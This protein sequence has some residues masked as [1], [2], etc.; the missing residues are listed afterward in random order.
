MGYDKIMIIIFLFC[1]YCLSAQ[2]LK[3]PKEHYRYEIK[4]DS[5]KKRTVEEY[6]LDKKGDKIKILLYDGYM[7]GGGKIVGTYESNSSLVAVDTNLIYA[8]CIKEI[9]WNSRQEFTYKTVTSHFDLLAKIFK[10]KKLLSREIIFFNAHNRLRTEVAFWNKEGIKVYS[11]FGNND[12]ECL[13]EWNAEGQLIVKVR[14]RWKGEKGVPG[15]QSCFEGWQKTWYDN[16]KL[17]YKILLK[18]SYV[19]KFKDWS[20]EGAVLHNE[21][22]RITSKTSLSD[23]LTLERWRD[24][25]KTYD[26]P[27][28]YSGNDQEVIVE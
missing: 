6:W 9:F 23:V 13:K 27:C 1:F 21:N 25:G 26:C 3:L 12:V 19:L 5:L 20:E 10:Q 4:D 18:D 15:K 17:Q 24:F 28:F 16:G 14:K 7:M 8:N 2:E 11:Y 22:Y